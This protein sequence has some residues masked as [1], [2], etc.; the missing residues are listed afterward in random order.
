M[1]LQVRAPYD[2]LGSIYSQLDRH[3]A[4]RLDEQYAED[5]SVAITA[6][7]RAVLHRAVPRCCDVLRCA[8]LWWAALG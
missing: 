5:G 1:T 2:V 6:Q 4:E 3:G 8:A 7:V